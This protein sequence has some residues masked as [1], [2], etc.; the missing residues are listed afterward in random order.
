MSG[1]ILIDAH[2]QVVM[3][4]PVVR[5]AIV[6]S[7]RLFRESL[8]CCLSQ[9]GPFCVVHMAAQLGE[10]EHKIAESGP[11]VLIVEFS[12]LRRQ[13]ER[14]DHRLKGMPLGVKALVIDVPDR[15][16]DILYCIEAGGASG[17]LLQNASL[18][19][20]DA[21]LQAVA[22]G[23]TLCSP[24]IAHLAFCRMSLFARQEE[25]VDVSHGAP[26]TRRETEVVRLIEEGLSNKEIATRLHVELSTVKNHVHNILDKLQLPN[27]YSVVKHA[28]ERISQADSV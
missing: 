18:K 4:T 26:L 10:T 2:G 5:I 17:Y 19:D 9:C 8:S 3:Q 28:K 15:E 24:R 7:N 14:N 25:R 6:H 20:L 13:D 23:E 1:G 12:L 16:A 22:R 27:R 21:N 11:H